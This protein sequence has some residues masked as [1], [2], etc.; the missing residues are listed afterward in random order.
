MVNPIA[1]S[2]TVNALYD[3]HLPKLTLR[4]GPVFPRI[5]FFDSPLDGHLVKAFVSV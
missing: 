4:V 2:S 1:F 5:I 3:E